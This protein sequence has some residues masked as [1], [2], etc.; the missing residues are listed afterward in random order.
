MVPY[1]VVAFV[2]FFLG[3]LLASLMSASGRGRERAEEQ[4]S[5]Q[6]DQGS[7]ATDGTLRTRADHLIDDSRAS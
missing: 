6:D 7:E 4:L 1:I 3:F 2:A 5:I